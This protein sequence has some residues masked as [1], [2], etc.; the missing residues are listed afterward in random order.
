MHTSV[1]I[2]P[3]ALKQFI[4][5]SIRIATTLERVHET[6]SVLGF[7]S[8]KIFPL[9]N[10][11]LEG[12]PNLTQARKGVHHPASAFTPDSPEWFS[13]E[14]TGR[15]G[16]EVDHRSDLYGVG[17]LLYT[18]IAQAP[19]F[20]AH[21]PLEWVHAHIALQPTPLR[22]R[23]TGVPSVLS[24]I[25][26]M[27]LLKAPEER[28]QSASAL[29][30]DLERCLN[31][32]KNGTIHSFPIA[33]NDQVDSIRLPRSVVGRKAEIQQL[34]QEMKAVSQGSSGKVTFIAGYSG[35]GKTALYEAAVHTEPRLPLIFARGKAEAFKQH[36]PYF[37]LSQTVG[38]ILQRLLESS[39]EMNAVFEEIKRRLGEDASLLIS[40][41]PIFESLFPKNLKSHQLSP[42]EAELRTR[43]ALLTLFQILTGND[44][45]VSLLFDDL[46]WVDD[47]SVQFIESLLSEL[48]HLKVHITITYRSNELTESHPA[49]PIVR[50]HG[51]NQILLGPLNLNA[52]ESTLSEMLSRPC[53]DLERLAQI[54]Q[55]KTEGNPFYIRVFLE[56]LRSQGILF[57]TGT[58][59]TWTWKESALQALPVTE[60]L[61]ASLIH[62]MQKLSPLAKELCAHCSCLGSS[63][64]SEEVE[65]TSGLDSDE[66]W[67]GLSVLVQ[68]GLLSGSTAS[69]SRSIRFQ[70]VHDRVL[71][72][73]TNLMT[74]QEAEIRHLAIARRTTRSTLTQAK[75]YQ[76]ALSQLQN[77][78]EKAAVVEI[79]L[80]AA[81]EEIRINA[82]Q[83]ALD[84]AS[85]ALSLDPKDIHKKGAQLLALKAEAQ[86]L[87]G[88][89]QNALKTIE[90]GLKK[91]S[92]T[93]TI[94]QL[95]RIKMNI[96][97]SM[98]S[99]K[100]ALQAGAH[101]A[102]LLGSEIP[103]DNPEAM[104]K[105]LE[106]EYK[107]FN[108]LRGEHSLRKILDTLEPMTDPKQKLL[109]SVY[110]EMA[111]NGFFSE[112][113]LA[114]T[115]IGNRMTNL[116]LA[117]GTTRE[118][119]YGLALFAAT[120]RLFHNDYDRSIDFGR[121]VE[122]LLDTESQIAFESR[123]RL[124]YPTWSGYWYRP[125]R[126]TLYHYR[127]G[128]QI[129]IATADHIWAAYNAITEA[130]YAFYGQ[131]PLASVQDDAQRYST[132]SQELNQQVMVVYSDLTFSEV[133]R[134]IDETQNV[135][136]DQMQREGLSFFEQIKYFHGVGA[137]QTLHGYV[138]F[139]MGD[140]DEM[141]RALESASPHVQNITLGIDIQ[142]FVFLTTLVAALQKDA[143]K[144][145]EGLSLFDKWTELCA[146]NVASK[147]AFL[148]GFVSLQEDRRSEAAQ[149]FQHA[150]QEAQK[151]KNLGDLGLAHEWLAKADPSHKA[152]HLKHAQDAYFEWGA[153]AKARQLS[154]SSETAQPLPSTPASS[155]SIDLETILSGTQALSKET[156][157]PKL[158]ETLLRLSCL[159]AGADRAVFLE[160]KEGTPSPL[161][162]FNPARGLIVDP[163]A[164]KVPSAPLQFCLRSQTPYH[165]ADESILAI[166]L[167]RREKVDSILFLENRTLARAF[168]GSNLE[169]LKILASQMLISIENARLY[170][171]MEQ[172]VEARTHE[173]SLAQR[174]L[175]ESARL[176]AL[177]EMAGGIA[178]EIN[179]PLTIIEGHLRRLQR[180]ASSDQ[181]HSLT[182]IQSTLSRIASITSS[183]LD[184]SR[185][186]PQAKLS[187]HSV[188]ELID[189]SL[190]LCKERVR[191]LPIELREDY[192]HSHSPTVLCNSIE[193]SQILLNLL[194]NAVDSLTLSETS[195]ARIRVGYDKNSS[196]DI[197]VWVEDNG[198]GI[199]EENRT[200][201]FEPFFSTKSEVTG[202]GLGL[203]VSSGLAKK[204]GANLSVESKPGRTRFMLTFHT[205][206]LI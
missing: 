127:I 95:H 12:T 149:H 11:V 21:T 179:N 171:A 161:Q 41:H 166:P 58:P 184:F 187:E 170:Q 191:S 90:D 29:R 61:S 8:P 83:R 116:T 67:T 66:V 163:G 115:L 155:T 129:G 72:A 156:Q 48:D 64:S 174:K 100:A 133:S 176:A 150:I 196:G 62:K 28:Y 123:I 175:V 77:A 194:N 30:S 19:L 109:M 92:E 189:S 60:N 200:R 202:V 51:S 137:I 122:H 173:L 142:A 169:V 132:L 182:M 107:E 145:Q 192:P 65:A 89:F 63:F 206:S 1:V 15:I 82:Y 88:D 42:R 165:D 24:E 168:T 7:V 190:T 183:L 36:T 73:A 53:T 117:S 180:G 113:F 203:S 177:G 135:T 37:V 99:F 35:I 148:K 38:Q 153:Y 172:E 147:S 45:G 181:N 3:K 71:E 159:N 81:A 158:I 144:T 199:S 79:C 188:V 5:T 75:H 110:A 119:L 108:T 78:K 193:I 34:Q 157:L 128:R 32:F 141:I 44:I 47:V 94:I 39:Q 151:Y 111:I 125:I 86:F 106:K 121:T 50:T 52:I 112:D 14:L 80:K 152:T 143:A 98:G 69:E 201:I 33:Q 198:P 178:H 55:K 85:A 25:I 197:T 205:S 10:G 204:N 136:W 118:N 22:E 114:F 104:E 195:N 102:E 120:P 103:L 18:T 17:N 138:Q 49:F 6:H 4:E 31:D 154:L 134:L 43:N 27:L 91:A 84:S 9:R 13:P 160:I 126:D 124:L 139:V 16:R 20:S 76:L 131:M 96:L 87:L 186:R 146:S 130:R 164:I 105:A 101:A 23:I 74:P 167:I 93:S 70:F 68:A 46:Q 26:E 2:Q 40:V 97:E 56:T 140:L 185:N 54:I 162:E 57:L 59:A